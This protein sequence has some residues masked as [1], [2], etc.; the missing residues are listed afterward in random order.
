MITNKRVALT[1]LH[2]HPGNY[3]HHPAKQM[4]HLQASYRRFGQFRSIVVQQ[5]A[6]NTYLIVAGHGMVEAM[7]AEGAQEV[8][9][10]I[11]PPDL[12]PT[13]INAIMVADNRLS[14][15]AEDDEVALLD[16]LQE[17]QGFDLFSVGYDDGE[18]QKLLQN[19]RMPKLEQQE[20]FFETKEEV[21]IRLR[22]TP[23]IKERYERLMRHIVA[24]DDTE[25]FRVL[26]S[27]VDITRLG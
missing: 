24:P 17:Q 15:L 6:P 14:Q 20:I 9:I 4:K 11:L 3:R 26:L 12:A 19:S 2:P 1:Q 21:Y 16:L 10:D 5:G 18:L 27:L 25:R 22:V 8:H 23:E 13:E 7:R